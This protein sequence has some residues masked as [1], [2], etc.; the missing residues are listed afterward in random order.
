MTWIV[1]SVF[2]AL[3]QAVRTAAQKT[4]NETMSNLGTTYVRSLVGLPIVLA[5]LVLIMLTL[6]PRWPSLTAAYLACTAAGA[7]AQ[8]IATM[9]LIYL[10]KLRNFAIGTML[11]KVDVV[12]TA[13]VGTLLFS[14]V[15][16]L[17]GVVAL[18]VVTLGVVLIS[19]GRVGLGKLRREGEA[20]SLRDA[21]FGLPTL[22]ALGSAFAFTLSYLFLREATLL[23]EPG[24]FLWRAAWT[25][26]IATALQTL[27]LGV[28]IVAREPAVFG[29]IWPKRR[30]IGFIGLTSAL[31]SIAWYAAFAIQNAS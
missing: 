7:A 31:G 22:V 24:H 15:L 16:S 1:I 6:E 3:M 29:Q 2:G 11:I 23:L 13:L 30:I 14:E 10:F 12:M 21:V 20:L 5:F 27:V 17:L 9:L 25:V 26:V 19:L 8:V 4:L 28:Y 18:L